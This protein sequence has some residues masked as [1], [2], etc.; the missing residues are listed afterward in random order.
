MCQPGRRPAKVTCQAAVA[1]NLGRERVGA[2]APQLALGG[3]P[4][5]PAGPL[6]PLAAA[7]GLGAANSESTE[8]FHMQ[9]MGCKLT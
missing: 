9:N 8:R 2:A 3:Q 6:H 7:R 5:L 4:V 1:V